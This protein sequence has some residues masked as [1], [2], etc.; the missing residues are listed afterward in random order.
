MA[1]KN[2]FPSVKLG[3]KKTNEASLCKFRIGIMH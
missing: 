2:I 3:F 1:S